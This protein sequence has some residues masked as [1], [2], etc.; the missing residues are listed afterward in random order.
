[1]T[2]CFGH[3]SVGG[4][5]VNA[6]SILGQQQIAVVE[7]S[8]PKAYRRPIFGHFRVGHN[9]DPLSKCQAFSQAMERGVGDLVDVAFFKLCYVDIASDTDVEALFKNYQETMAR[10]A[11]RYPAVTFLHVTVPLRHVRRNV[12]AWLHQWSGRHDGEREAQAR[13]HAFNQLLR[14]HYAGTGRLFDLADGEATFPDGRPS[15]F[16]YQGRQL[17]NLVETYTDD[18]GHLNKQAAE[19]AARRLLACLSAVPAQSRG[20]TEGQGH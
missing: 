16:C 2:V 3:Q 20:L 7:T 6:I 15:Y 5:I 9:G 10:L 11:E 13:R 1:M 14:G 19:L 4:D 8:D 17:P 12:R 18:G